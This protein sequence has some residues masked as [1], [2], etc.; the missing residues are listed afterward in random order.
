MMAMELLSLGDKLHK[1]AG[2]F[3][4]RRFGHR[5]PSAEGL[6]LVF[7]AAPINRYLFD[8]AHSRS[9]D[10]HGEGACIRGG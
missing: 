9:R 8:P 6:A 1:A 2:E 3:Q 4:H 10:E 7:G 5:T